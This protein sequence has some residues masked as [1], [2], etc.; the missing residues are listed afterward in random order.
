MAR[1]AHRNID[2]RDA[3]ITKGTGATTKPKDDGSRSLRWW[4]EPAKDRPQAIDT[5]LSSIWEQS[6]YRLQRLHEFNWLYGN[7]SAAF[8]IGGLGGAYKPLRPAAQSRV[9]YN[10]IQTVVDTLT[11]KIAKQS[12]KPYFLTSGGNYKQQRKSKKRNK[13][14][15][16]VFYENNSKVLT[17][18][19]F[20]D[21]CVEGTGIVYVF[22][23]PGTNRVQLERVLSSELYVDDADGFYGSPRCMYRVKNVDRRVLMDAF[24]DKAAKLADLNAVQF[25]SG[26][27]SFQADLI[28]VRIAWHLPSG[29]DA[30]DGRVSVSV[31]DLELDSAPYTRDHFP[32]AVL[33][34]SPRLTGFYGQSLCEQLE[35]IQLE[36]NRLCWVIQRSMYLAGSY[37]VWLPVGSKIIKEGINNDLA[38]VGLYAGTQPPQYLLPPIVQKEIYEER[39]RLKQWAFER[40]GL[41]SLSATAE[42]PKGLD[43]GEALRTFDSIGDDRLMSIWSLYERFHVEL[44]TL[45]IEAAA[46]A[47]EAGDGY[48]VAVPGMR[49]STTIRYKDI[50]FDEDEEPTIECFPISSLPSEPAGRLQTVQEYMQAGLVSQRQGKKLLNFPD[51]EAVDGR[52]SAE[53]DYLLMVLDKIVDDGVFTPPDPSDNLQLALELVLDYE[54]QARLGGLEPER[55]EMLRRFRTQVNKMAT[56]AAP[57]Q[58]APGG[59][60]TGQPAA[61]PTSQLLPSAPGAAPA[62]G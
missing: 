19:A 59:A 36:M 39:D 26:T 22:C 5:V 50:A 33:R 3:Q 38:T 37:K 20:R 34:V 30:K 17:V 44:G 54:A 32:F 49:A 27:G 10:V 11:A 2:A 4:A 56:P 25:T 21:A 14:L 61:P 31:E 60:P 41:S 24:P 53:E 13:F 42:K 47:D 35:G 62:P 16:G 55:L 58:A 28:Q 57:A 43:S 18:Q 52:D 6:R 46:E 23:A 51:L 45:A 7:A 8:A 48:E 40:V 1:K 29:P 9:T 12:P 15:D